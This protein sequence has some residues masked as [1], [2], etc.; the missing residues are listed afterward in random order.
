MTHTRV[1]MHTPRLP[2]LLAV[3]PLLLVLCCAQH[4]ESPLPA[5][6]DHPLELR[7]QPW[8]RRGRP[9][10][11]ADTTQQSWSSKMLYSPT[12]VDVDGVFKMWYVG[13]EGDYAAEQ[14][15]LN[16]GYAESGDGVRL[17]DSR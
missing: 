12:V 15:V 7:P 1:V 16:I 5:S 6:E 2:A 10:L 8:Q 11:S 4:E 3:A 17:P 14:G 13:S 9:V